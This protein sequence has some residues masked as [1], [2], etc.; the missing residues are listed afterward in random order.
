MPCWF[1]DDCT[2]AG[3]AAAAA[4]RFGASERH[5]AHMLYTLS[6]VQILALYDELERLDANRV[7]ECAAPTI[8]LWPCWM[9]GRL[10]TFLPG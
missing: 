9:A 5:D 10:D 3:M 7:A 8:S 2:V 6:A 1:A 4:R